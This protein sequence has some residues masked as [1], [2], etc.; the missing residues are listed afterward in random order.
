MPTV[1]KLHRVVLAHIFY[2]IVTKFVV[3]QFHFLLLVVRFFFGSDC[4]FFSIQHWMH[5]SG[6]ILHTYDD[7][8]NIA[9]FKSHTEYASTLW[10]SFT[11]FKKFQWYINARRHL[12][13]KWI[14]WSC[15]CMCVCVTY[16][17]FSFH[18]VCIETSFS[19]NPSV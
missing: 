13:Y 11:L 5:N 1:V 6:S 16:S 3:I 12:S 15:E 9:S 8:A 19:F 7:N 10:I 14:M 2:G 17:T 4:S 18:S